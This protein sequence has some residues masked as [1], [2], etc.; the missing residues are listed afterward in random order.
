MKTAGPIH[1][2]CPRCGEVFPP[3]KLG[4]VSATFEPD[5]DYVI[6][7]EQQIA[8]DK[9]SA[10]YEAECVADESLRYHWAAF[11]S[12]DDKMALEKLSAVELDAKER[13]ETYLCCVPGDEFIESQAASIGR[14]ITEQLTARNYRAARMIIDGLLNLRDKRPFKATA[15]RQLSKTRWAVMEAYRQLEQNGRVER[16]SRIEVR[17]WLKKW[18][19]IRISA[20]RLSKL[21]D[22]LGL[23]QQASDARVNTSEAGKRRRRKV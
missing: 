10:D 8:A 5:R 18:M 17:D 23:K 9:F 11:L 6:T 3:V 4:H 22:E 12:D 7:A 1:E 21:F 19:N 16:P 2:T 20:D 13:C 15:G 14:F